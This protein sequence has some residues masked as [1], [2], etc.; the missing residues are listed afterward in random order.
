MSISASQISQVIPGVLPAGGNNASLVTLLLSQNTSTPIGVPVFFT[1]AE[2]VGNQY[3]FTSPE[4][5]FASVYFAGISN[6]LAL[7]GQL[8]VMQYPETAVAAWLQSGSL[9]GVTLAE[10][11]AMSGVLT[12]TCN[13]TEFA[14]ASINLSAATSFSNAA[15]LIQAAFTSPT[16]TVTWSSQLN[17]FVITSTTTG[18]TSAMSYGSGSIATP[19]L[20]AQANGAVTSQG[21]A[22]ATPG[23]FMPAVIAATTQWADFST[24]WESQLSE[25]VAFAQWTSQQGNEYAYVMYDSDVNNASAANFSE[26]AYAA[27]VAAGYGGAIPIYGNA[28][29]AAMVCAWAASLDFSATNGRMDLA[30]IGSP[31]V[32]PYVTNSA[33]AAQLLLNGVNFYGDYANK[34]TRF[35]LF[36]N[37][38]ISGPYLWADSYMNQIAFNDELQSDQLSLLASGVS[39]PYNAAGNALIEACYADTIQKYLNFGAIRTGVTLSSSQKQALF[40]KIGVDVSAQIQAVGYYLYIGPE[41]AAIRTARTSPP[42]SLFYTDGGDVQQLVLNSVEIQ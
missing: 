40:A 25:K 26:T 10:L 31:S 12:V 39:I 16:F 24:A 27:I 21:A 23:T 15:S 29:H 34:G 3:G 35:Q 7:P 4:Y 5:E 36:Q 30:G 11:Q 13:G 22:A 38:A 20:L 28:T 9:A 42:I 8:I 19:L 14:S 33:I 2:A 1:S 18:T 37:G 32:I 17:A 41:T 6:A